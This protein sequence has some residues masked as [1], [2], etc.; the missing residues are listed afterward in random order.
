MI[1]YVQFWSKS[2]NN[3]KL[4]LNSKTLF[5]EGFRR[6]VLEEEKGRKFLL[7]EALNFM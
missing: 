4:A 1:L 3:S 7:R 2:W 6:I 5:I